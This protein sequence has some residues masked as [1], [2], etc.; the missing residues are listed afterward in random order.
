MFSWVQYHN[1]VVRLRP[2]YQMSIHPGAFGSLS[3]LVHLDLSSNA[4]NHLPSETVKGLHKLEILKVSGDVG[5]SF[6]LG[7]NWSIHRRAYRYSDHRIAVTV[8][9]VL[10]CITQVY[11]M[12][13]YHVEIEHD[14][15]P[16]L[17]HQ[18]P[19]LTMSKCNFLNHGSVNVAL[20]QDTELRIGP[21]CADKPSNKSQN[22]AVVL[23]DM[24]ADEHDNYIDNYGKNVTTGFFREEP[25][26]SSKW[27]AL[28]A[29]LV[30]MLAVVEVALVAMLACFLVK[31]KG[32]C[33]RGNQAAQVASSQGNQ[34][35]Q[36]AQASVGSPLSI[37]CLDHWMVGGGNSH[38]VPVY[39]NQG[40]PGSDRATGSVSCS[41]RASRSGV[42]QQLQYS[43]IPDEYYYKYENMGTSPPE[44]VRTYW[45]I[46]DDYYNY[47]NTRPAFLHQ[48]W[49]IGDDYYN[50]ENTAGR[51]LSLPLALQVPLSSGHDDEL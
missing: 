26:N 50:Y 17:A 4:L 48:Y 45:Q 15:S 38:A 14:F 28:H 8:N 32:Y 5:D 49:E 35:A 51:P 29:G 19:D 3:Q 13:Q 2:R 21:I 33:S 42:E 39:I 20:G 27:R 47:Y 16:K 23:Y 30:T 24:T 44:T 18:N 10:F 41:Q 36:G 46:P 40:T 1:I 6:L 11:K 34:A 9:E 22:A 31:K 25:K 7:M 37:A 43:E 12:R